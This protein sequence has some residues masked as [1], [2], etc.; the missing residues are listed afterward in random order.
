MWGLFPLYFRHIAAVPPLEVVLH[1]SAWSLLFVMGLLA[2]L[3]RFGWLR[4]LAAQPRRLAFLR[5]ER[6]AAGGQLVAVRVCGTERPGGGGQPGL[7]HQPDRQRT[8]RRA[9][10]ARAAEQGA[11]VRSGAGG[12]RRAVV[13]A[14]RRPAA[15]D[16]T[17]AGGQLRPVWPDAQDRVAGRAGRAGAGDTAARPVGAAG[18]GLVELQR[19]RCHGP[20]RPGTR[21]L[22]DH[23]RAVDRP[24][25]AAVCRQRP[26]PAA[27]HRGPAAVPVTHHPTRAGRLGLP[28]AL[29]P[30]TPGR[31]RLHLGRPGTVFGE[32][33]APFAPIAAACC[34]RRRAYGSGSRRPPAPP[35][36]RRR[37]R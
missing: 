11:M 15:L 34:L 23:R 22:A 12:R 33:M 25:A 37:P 7:L 32:R 5:P 14:A 10:A 27:G 28:R 30:R 18:P 24:A 29:R 4:E 19:P 20:G 35:W 2:A 31:L 16:C 8:A 26:P 17:D 3:R 36:R 1:R 9:G 13:D 6:T 21:R